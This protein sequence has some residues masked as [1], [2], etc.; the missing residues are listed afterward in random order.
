MNFVFEST[1]N[2]INDKA[3]RYLTDFTKIMISQELA[4]QWEECMTI[5]RNNIPQPQIDAWFAPIT[6]LSYDGKR[7]ELHV[8]SPYTCEHLETHFIHIIKPVIRRVFGDDTELFYTYNV[9]D[10]EKQSEVKVKTDN[11]SPVAKSAPSNIHPLDFAAKSEDLPEVDSH[12]NPRYTFENYCGSTCNNL[13]RSIGEAIANDPN[14]KTFNPLFI[15]GPSGV[16]KTHLMHAIGIGIKEK[17]P[18]ARVLYVTA[19]LFEGQYTV[20]SRN[21]KHNEFIQFYQTIDCLIIDDIQDLMGNKE[22]T[23]NAFFH[24]FNHL[25]L[26][27]KQIILSSDCAPSNMHGLPERLLTR[28]KW[29]MTV[30]LERPDLELRMQV[31]QLR[32]EQEG[33]NLPSDVMEYIAQNVTGSIREI[34]GIMVSLMAHATFLN[35]EIT[36]DLARSIIDRTPSSARRQ[37]NFEIIAQN[38]SGYYKI[39]PELLFTQT[40]KRE[41]SD[42]RQMVM[43]LAKKHI[44]MP[45]TTIGAR[46]SR[47]HATVLHGCKSIEERLTFE[48]QLQEDVT[49]IEQTF[50]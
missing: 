49:A 48:K 20:A 40:R 38:V 15:H 16:G 32:S 13:A 18:T 44:N 28:F 35:E 4:T 9:I 12:L 1:N 47:T 42:A 45:F 24:I 5:F 36:T 33:I 39:E 41:V 7:L 19:R 8:P 10:G 26:N 43:Y 30:E 50:T 34:E 29:G 3:P 27:Q 46:L 2:Q 22:K 21:G 23:Q 25:R 31:L 14:C 17:T 37:L 11:A 6:P